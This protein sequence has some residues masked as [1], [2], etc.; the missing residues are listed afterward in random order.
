MADAFENAWGITKNEMEEILEEEKEKKNP[1]ISMEKIDALLRAIGY[2]GGMDHFHHPDAAV[3]EL[4]YRLEAHMDRPNER[5]Q[6]GF[7]RGNEE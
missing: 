1:E 2:K 4:I 5:D 3:S 7:S 6:F